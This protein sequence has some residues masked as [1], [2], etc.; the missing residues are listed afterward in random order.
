M[1]YIRAIRRQPVGISERDTITAVLS[2]RQRGLERSIVEP[3][4]I[5]RRL[6]GRHREM[7]GHDRLIR[8]D[9]H[10]HPGPQ[11]REHVTTVPLLVSCKTGERRILVAKIDALNVRRDQRGDRIGR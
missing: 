10:P 2:E 7:S 1:K 5:D 11:R 4:E 8:H 9:P 3:N 6:T